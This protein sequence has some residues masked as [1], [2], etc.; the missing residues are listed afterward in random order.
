MKAKL[1]NNQEKRE[2]L[3]THSVD[4][5]IPNYKDMEK[6]SLITVFVVN[7]L[8]TNA[9]II[10]KSYNPNISDTLTT[11]NQRFLNLKKSLMIY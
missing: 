4:E 10:E 3:V 6:M 2:N 11:P 8:I 9:M 1:D 7:I 5:S